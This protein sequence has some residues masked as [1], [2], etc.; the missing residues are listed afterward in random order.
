MND[1]DARLRQFF[2]GYFNQ[3][4]DIGGGKSWTE[5]VAQYVKENARAR[6]MQVQDDLRSWLDETASNP[7]AGLP[8]NFGCDYDP[9]PDGLAVREWVR[10]V[11]DSLANQITS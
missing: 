10:L 11:A 5:V 9:R 4:W 7:T 1:R 8:A 2:G 6:V 3:D